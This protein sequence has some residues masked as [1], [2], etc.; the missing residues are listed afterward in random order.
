[1]LRFYTFGLTLFLTAC[2]MEAGSDVATEALSPS[3]ATAEPAA[4]VI[5]ATRLAPHVRTDLADR[6]IRCEDEGVPVVTSTRAV[7]TGERGFDIVVEGLHCGANFESAG[8]RAYTIEGAD[9]TGRAWTHI[10]RAD[11]R[12]GGWFTLE[13]E[14]WSCGALTDAVDLMVWVQSSASVVEIST[15]VLEAEP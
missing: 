2:G 6:V 3:G 10:Q 15:A 4:P 9:I 8:F 5:E 12:R 14:A 13:L 7:R 11:L 1:M